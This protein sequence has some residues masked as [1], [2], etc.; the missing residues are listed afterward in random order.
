MAEKL[1]RLTHKIA[2]Q[3]HPMADT[4]T[5][6]S[7]RSRRPNPK[8]LDTPSY[9]PSGELGYRTGFVLHHFVIGMIG[10]SIPGRGWE[11]FS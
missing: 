7:Y 10:T 5:I 2:I 6:C 8:L 11:L 3:L 9:V 1:T 4:C